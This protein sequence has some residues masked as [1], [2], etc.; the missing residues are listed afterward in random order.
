MGQKIKIAVVA[1]LWKLH[2]CA[3]PCTVNTA[4]QYTFNWI[5]RDP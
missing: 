1:I 5:A 2:S 4:K 3:M